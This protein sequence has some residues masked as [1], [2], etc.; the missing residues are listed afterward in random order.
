MKYLYYVVLERIFSDSA[1]NSTG[2][3]YDKAMIYDFAEALDRNWIDEDGNRVWVLKPDY[4][5]RCI[6]FVYG[7]NDLTEA[8]NFCEA[9][10]N[11]EL[12]IKTVKGY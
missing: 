10:T 11:N 9:L 1:I 6:T 4:E 3:I 7:F 5:G 8:V 12:G 2:E